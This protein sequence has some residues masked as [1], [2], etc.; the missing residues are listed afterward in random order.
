MRHDSAHG[1]HQLVQDS[2]RCVALMG[3]RGCW[4]GRKRTPNMQLALGWGGHGSKERLKLQV[5]I[6]NKYIN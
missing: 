2:G 3:E 5:G 6:L 1:E 4:L